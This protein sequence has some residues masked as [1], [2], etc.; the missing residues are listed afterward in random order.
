MAKRVSVFLADGFEEIEG[1]TVVDLI[2]RAKIE[3]EM[4]SIMEEMPP[5]LSSSS[6][7]AFPVWL[8]YPP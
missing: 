2:R 3:T 5:A 1:L 6:R 7:S 8:T 4:V